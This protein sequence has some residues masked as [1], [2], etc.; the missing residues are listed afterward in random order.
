MPLARDT[1]MAEAV[2]SE[3]DAPRTS[4]LS[5]GEALVLESV[6][7]HA[8]AW[9]RTAQKHS[10]CLDDAYDAYQRGLEILVRRVGTLDPDQVGNWM[11]TV[12]K[13]EAMAVRKSRLDLVHTD[14]VDLERQAAPHDSPEDHALRADRATRAAEALQRL[15][16]QERRAIWLKSIGKSYREICEETGWTY[17]KVNR[18]LAEGRKRFLERFAGIEAGKECER[19]QDLLSAV[20]DGEAT[21]EQ[22]AELRP[23][24]RNCAACRATLRAHHDAQRSLS[25]LLPPG[26]IG[27][28]A[29]ASGLLERLLP[30]A[31]A[32]EAAGAAAAGGAGLLGVGGAKLLTLLAAG[33]A[34]T[35]GGIAVKAKVD[36]GKERPA[37]ARRLQHAAPARPAVVSAGSTRAVV[38]TP[39]RTQG[40]SRPTTQ[41][42]PTPRETRRAE[43][44]PGGA[45]VGSGGPTTASGAA[46]ASAAAPAPAPRPNPNRPQPA[47]R[48]PIPVDVDS[49]SGEFAPH[50]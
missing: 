19:W 43:F 45:P 24:L 16:P 50:P 4:T 9:L 33:A 15:K 23:H 17:T 41:R 28:T 12:V 8:A 22:I 36:R 14:A 38:K 6:A 44:M 29:K 11:H 5:G 42:K 3:P 7:R 32:P 37:A 30:V 40:P 2:V 20:A 13:H 47:R 27:L 18:C 48:P 35:G 10:L 26:L 31:P 25:A 39:T 21:E 49:A 34:A 1:E 46:A